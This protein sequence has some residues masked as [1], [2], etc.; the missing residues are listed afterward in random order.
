MKQTAPVRWI[1]LLAALAIAGM[2]AAAQGPRGGGGM[3]GG[4]GMGMP[5]GMPDRGGM[6]RGMGNGSGSHGSAQLA[7]PGRWW[8]DKKFARTLGLNDA[9]QR[10]MDSVFVQNREA[11]LSRYETLQREQSKLDNLVHSDHPDESTLSAQIDRVSQARADL[12]KAYA[13]YQ[14]QLRDEMSADQLS[15]LDSTH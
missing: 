10:R 12:G 1:T 3:G 8:D 15:K 13:H 5:G 2:T 4:R 7:P 9:Q 14:L 6:S 11:L